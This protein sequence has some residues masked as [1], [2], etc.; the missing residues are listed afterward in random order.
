MAARVYAFPT[1]SV[2][3]RRLRLPYLGLPRPCM[4]VS[5]AMLLGGLSVPF[6]MLL[7]LLPSSLILAALG[8]MLTL[9]GSVLALVYRGEIC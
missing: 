4:I 6:L 8:L 5:H 2:R 3:R 1:Y 9:T 7:G